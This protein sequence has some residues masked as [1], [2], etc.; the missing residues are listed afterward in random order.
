MND[1]TTAPAPQGQR[2]EALG[3]QLVKIHDMLRGEL[4]ALRGD[5]AAA[6]DSPSGTAPTLEQQLRKKC[7]SFCEFLHGHHTAEDGRLLPGLARSHPDL[8]PVLERLTRE[9]SVI[10]RALDRIQELVEGG[11]P[12]LVRDEVERLAGEVEAHL[13]YE[14][15]QIVDALNSYGPVTL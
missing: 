1:D 6:G 7:L 11:D 5:L 9:H 2:I 3:D 8:A 10:S 13:D 4:A 14:E 15:R 12:V